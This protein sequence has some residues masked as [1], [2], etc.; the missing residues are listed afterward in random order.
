MARIICD[1]CLRPELGC[2][3]SYFSTTENNISIVILQHPSEVKQTKGSVPLLQHSL[4]QCVTLVGEEHD[5]DG[6]FQ[7]LLNKYHGKIALLY[8]SENAQQLTEM[9]KK[10]SST[11]HSTSIQCL[12]LLDGTWKKAYRLYQLNPILSTLP[13]IKLPEG[14]PSLYQARTTKKENALSTLEACCHALSYLEADD[15]KYQSLLNSFALFNQQ[16][17]SFTKK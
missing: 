16:L 4:T 3:C 2:I 11:A 17:L 10:P 6:Q 9:I 14:I 8:P 15:I 5:G 7:H 13:H 12:I 1:K